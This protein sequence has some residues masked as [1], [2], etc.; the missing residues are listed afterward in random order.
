MCGVGVCVWIRQLQP[1][2]SNGCG[3]GNDYPLDGRGVVCV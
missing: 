3:E 2:L 1:T